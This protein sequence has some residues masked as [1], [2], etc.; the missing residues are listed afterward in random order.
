MSSMDQDLQWNSPHR[1]YII[2]QASI[3]AHPIEVIQCYLDVSQVIML[4]EMVM[5]TIMAGLEVYIPH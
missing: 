3:G 5:H 4:R 1:V 2:M